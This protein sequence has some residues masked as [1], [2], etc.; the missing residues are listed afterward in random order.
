MS[1][2]LVLT[3]GK[4]KSLTLAWTMKLMSMDLALV[5]KITYRGV[6]LT[7]HFCTCIDRAVNALQLCR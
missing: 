7:N 5:M 6:R 2:A 4:H 3:S 1:L